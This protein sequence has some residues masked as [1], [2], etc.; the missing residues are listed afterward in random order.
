MPAS[1]LR[2]SFPGLRGLRWTG[3]TFYRLNVLWENGAF[4]I[5]DLHCLDERVVSPTHDTALTATSL[6]YE[7]LPIMDWAHWSKTGTRPAGMWPLLLSSDG[8][9]SPM[10]P[11]GAPVV[12]ELNAT[13]GQFTAG[14]TL[15]VVQRRAVGRLCFTQFTI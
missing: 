10:K 5:R 4:F 14:A 11:A 15:D 1:S 3:P 6:A 8:T 12:T 7:T 2:P 13:E 9:T